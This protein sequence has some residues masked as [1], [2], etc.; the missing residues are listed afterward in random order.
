MSGGGIA[1]DTTVIAT[2]PLGAETHV[3]L[4]ATG[5]RLRVKVP[6]FDAPARGEAVR[7]FVPESTVLWFD[8]A[9]GDRVRAQA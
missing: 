9:S 6:G 4:D 5:T 2:E 8:G 1:L 7:V 3:L